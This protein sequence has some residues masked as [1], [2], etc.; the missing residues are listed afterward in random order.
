MRPARVAWIDSV[1]DI[2]APTPDAAV[3]SKGFREAKIEHSHGAVG[4]NLDVC[5]LQIAMDD[6]LLVCR[7]ERLSYL[8]S[9]RQRFV[10]RERGPRVSAA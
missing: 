5:W 8:F 6:P 1:G 9:D 2:V 7:F 3:G 10:E 4:A